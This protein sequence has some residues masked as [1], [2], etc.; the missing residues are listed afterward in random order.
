MF[1]YPS[2]QPKQP[3]NR[4]KVDVESMLAGTLIAVAVLGFA[5]CLLL[6]FNGKAGKWARQWHPSHQPQQVAP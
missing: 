1:I 3:R 4:P 6:V 5:A 2:D